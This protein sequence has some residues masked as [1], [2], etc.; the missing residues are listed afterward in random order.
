MNLQWQTPPTLSGAVLAGGRAGRLQGQD[1]TKLQF[2]GRS[3]LDRTLAILGP[4]CDEKLVSSNS[5]ESYTDCKIVP[6]RRP[7]QGPLGA[8]YSC[9]RAAR[10]P[11]LLIVATDMPFITTAAL[12]KLWLERNGFDVVIPRSPDGLQPLAALYSRK[13]ITPIR[14]QLERGN[15]RIRC[16]FPQIRSK[17]ID[18]RDFPEIYHKNIF[19]NVNSPADLEKARSLYRETNHETNHETN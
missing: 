11:Y 1:K 7:G 6:D 13:C 12:Q 17:V 16:F 2:G 10:N 9:L 3:L 18:C 14:Y 5:L 4:I 15:L 8:L 19:L